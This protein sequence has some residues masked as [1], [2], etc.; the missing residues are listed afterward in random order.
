MS[1]S[2]TAADGR[3]VAYLVGMQTRALL[4]DYIEHHS[5]CPGADTVEEWLGKNWL[6]MRVGQQL[7]PV[8]PLWGIREALTAHDVHH[9]LT[10]YPTSLKGECQLAG[11]E[12]ASGGCRWNV[13]FWVDRLGALAL[14]LVLYPGATLKA[15]RHGWGARNL[16]GMGPEN[17]LAADVQAL[18]ERMHL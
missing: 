1:P 9:A 6:E 5:L 18:R 4:A 17:I 10:G 8:I 14:G 2:A 13:F 16:Y 15:V 7:I 11:W 3:R 12:L